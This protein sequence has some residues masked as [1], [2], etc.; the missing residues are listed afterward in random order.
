MKKYIILGVVAGCMALLIA[1]W[2]A[3]GKAN[4]FALK[5][6]IMEELVG[7]VA[8]FYGDNKRLPLNWDEFASWAEKAHTDRNWA[9]DVPE[10][11][12]KIYLREQT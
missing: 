4:L 6:M 7:D 1:G 5:G 8:K 9:A 10:L 2:W 12:V 11:K 3:V